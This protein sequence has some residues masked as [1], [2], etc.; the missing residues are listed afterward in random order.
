MCERTER[1]SFRNSSVVPKVEPDLHT[2]SD[3]KV[4]AP[5]HCAQLHEPMKNISEFLFRAIYIFW[6]HGNEL[7]LSWRHEAGAPSHP[8]PPPPTPPPPKKKKN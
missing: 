2:G 6:R 4:P 3:Q 7:L 5:Q 1:I 8:C